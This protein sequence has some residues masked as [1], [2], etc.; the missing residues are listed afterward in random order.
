MAVEL[1]YRPTHSQ[2]ALPFFPDFFLIGAPR[3]GTTAMSH[4]LGHHP[5]ICFSRPKEPHFFSLL[6]KRYP[7]LDESYYLSH[8]FPHYDP[9]RHQVIGEGSV[10]YLYDPEAIARILQLNPNA[11]FLVMVRNPVDLVYSYHARLVALLEEDQED[12][13]R[14]W[15]LQASRQRGEHLPKL[16]RNPLL[17]QYAEIGYLGKHLARL[18][19][20]V[21]RERCLVLVFDDFAANPLASYLKTLRFLGVAYDGRTEF[22]RKEGNK[23]PRF[24]WLQ[25]WLTRPPQQMESFLATLEYQRSRKRPNRHP[26]KRLR[27]FLLKNNLVYRPRPPLPPALKEELLATFRDDIELL[28]HLLNRDLSCWMRL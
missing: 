4:Y 23:Y 28:S 12:F 1:T 22:P 11:R 16:C 21:E 25:R 3:C 19:Q 17:L 6:R 27:K 15:R 7:E 5:N 20:Q 14:A 26:L 24:K 2:T 8:C 18:F 13:S 10:S 9:D